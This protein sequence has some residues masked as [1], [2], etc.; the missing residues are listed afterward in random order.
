MRITD[1]AKA[2]FRELR[3]IEG[4]SII[5]DEII[6]GFEEEKPAF[7]LQLNPIKTEYADNIT[8]NIHYFPKVKTQLELFEMSDKLNELFGNFYLKVTENEVVKLDE[9]R[10]EYDE[11]FLQYKFDM[12]IEHEVDM[13][14]EKDYEMMEHLEM[15][16]ENLD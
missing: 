6:S 10:I 5:S 15:R 9:I 7:F 3:K 11:N 4:V 14:D 2:I 1:I 13:F 8:A 12:T 16:F